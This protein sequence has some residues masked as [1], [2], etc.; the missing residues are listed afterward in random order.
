MIRLTTTAR[1]RGICSGLVLASLLVLAGLGPACGDDDGGRS[2]TFCERQ[3]GQLC[4]EAEEPESCKAE[5]IERC[6]EDRFLGGYG[7]APVADCDGT[8]ATT[9]IN[10]SL[11]LH[12]FRDSGVSE[13][14]A[15]D[16]TQGLQRYY[17]VYALDFYSALDP[18]PTHIPH[19]M[20]GNQQEFTTALVEAGVPIGGDLTPE[21]EK[22]AEEAVARV[23]FKPLRRFM[24]NH[25]AVGKGVNVTITRVI[26][27]QELVDLFGAEWGSVAGLGI[28]PTL[29][30]AEEQDD[31]NIEMTKLLGLSESF[32]PSLFV[33]HQVLLEYSPDYIDYIIAHEMGHALGLQ[34]VY[35]T[36]NLMKQGGYDCR[37]YLE[38]WQL[39]S[40]VGVEPPQTRRRAVAPR[41]EP[42]QSASVE[43]RALPSGNLRELTRAALQRA[44][45]LV[46]D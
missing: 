17:E 38:E 37:P 32:K 31:P 44:L 23:M 20:E 5:Q 7:P 8:P 9:P 3:A 27:A 12:L 6:V 21:Q 11:E 46:R 33:G 24:D 1:G 18:L 14:Q 42:G 39:L 36:G 34:H 41:V 13:G 30:A 40:L 15:I 16:E 2:P 43:G 4:A 22:R 35:N 19:L 45:E 28:S 29:L 10:G 26:V 25:G